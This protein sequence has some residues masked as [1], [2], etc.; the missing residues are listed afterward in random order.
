MFPIFNIEWS[1][2][3]AIAQTTATGGATSCIVPDV[4][5]NPI[6]GTD[7][8]ALL[9]CATAQAKHALEPG[10]K[11]EADV[12]GQMLKDLDDQEAA[13]PPFNFTPA[14]AGDP[15]MVCTPPVATTCPQANR[16]A[17]ADG[18]WIILEPL[19][20][21]THK[22]HFAASVPFPELNFTFTTDVTYTVTIK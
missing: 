11:L 3:E 13:S 16:R 7:D 9:A 4:N 21:G 20:K 17:E 22:I 1:K 5:G 18:F 19:G 14:S 2:V 10:A 12:D 6:K 8:A 15:F